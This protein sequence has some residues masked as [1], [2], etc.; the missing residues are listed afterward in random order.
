MVNVVATTQCGHL[1]DPYHMQVLA[2]GIKTWHPDLLSGGVSFAIISDRL[3]KSGPDK[4]RKVSGRKDHIKEPVGQN[5]LARP[6][7]EFLVDV[8]MQFLDNWVEDW[9]GAEMQVLL[10]Q[11]LFSKDRK[12]KR[13][14]SSP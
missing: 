9:E 1:P 4:V 12:S 6:E 3:F 7:L 11:T 2:S 5:Q 14:N 10:S 13:L 8:Q